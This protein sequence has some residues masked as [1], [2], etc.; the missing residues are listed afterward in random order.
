MLSMAAL[1]VMVRAE[2]ETAGH[3]GRGIFRYNEPIQGTGL[4]EIAMLR[5]LHVLLFVAFATTSISASAEDKPAGFL[6]CNMRSDGS[7]I[8]DIN[9]DENGKHLIPVGTP[10]KV[11]GYGRYRVRVDI[12]G[13]SQAIGNDY[14]RDLALDV[15]AKRYVVAEDPRVKIA[16]FPKKIQEAIASSRVSIGMT[17]E[18]VMMSVGYP[19]SSENHN[20]DDKTWRF[21]LTS[22]GEYHV[23]FD[24]SNRVTEVAGDMPTKSKVLME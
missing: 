15:F 6:C 7:W 18:Q 4:G 2:P 16:G 21:W 22:F 13:K 14:S 1:S 8:S 9:Y 17:R 24:E 10:I 3:A 20:I 19:V 11:T 23:S 12:D 5:I